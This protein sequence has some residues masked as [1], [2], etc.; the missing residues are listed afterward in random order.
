MTYLVEICFILSDTCLFVLYLLRHVYVY[1]VGVH[2]FV[3]LAENSSLSRS[4]GSDTQVR[5][6]NLSHLSINV[7]K[8]II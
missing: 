3:W 1:M 2:L 8:A 6:Q 4:F 5:K 7:I